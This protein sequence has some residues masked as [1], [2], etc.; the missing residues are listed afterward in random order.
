MLIIG[1]V[2]THPGR[3][4]DPISW[5]ALASSFSYGTDS[6]LINTIELQLLRRPKQLEDGFLRFS[7]LP[8]IFRQL[9]VYPQAQVTFHP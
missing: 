3:P 9:G 6:I 7:L 1:L 8:T 2:I 4:G 5:H